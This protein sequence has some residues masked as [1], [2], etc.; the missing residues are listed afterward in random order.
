MWYN[1]VMKKKCLSSYFI[2]LMVFCQVLAVVPAGA[3]D[4]KQEESI[5]NHCDTIIEDLKKVQRDDAKVRVHLG[6]E[7]DAILNRFILPLNVK[8]VEKNLSTADFVENQNSFV[9]TKTTFSNDYISYQ[10][11]LEELVAMD[12]KTEPEAFYEKLEKVRQKRK[13][14]EQDTM[15][16]RNLI[17]K[18]IR[19]V[20]SLKEKV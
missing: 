12:C 18:N 19:L 20:G 14:M 9:E 10:Q 17:S 7:Y 3:L 2:I 4:K 16:L 13:T 5:K 11:Q 15:L 1:K 6:G 8:L